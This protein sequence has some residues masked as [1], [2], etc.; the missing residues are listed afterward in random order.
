LYGAGVAAEKAG[1]HEKAKQYYAQLHAMTSNSNRPEL[2][3]AN[4]FLNKNS[5]P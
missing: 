3:T 1:N 4:R 2:V 5:T